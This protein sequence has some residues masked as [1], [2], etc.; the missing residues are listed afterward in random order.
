MLK[1]FSE[2]AI[3]YV[4]KLEEILRN[5]YIPETWSYVLRDA[6]L[7]GILSVLCL[8]SF[9]VARALIKYFFKKIIFRTKSK[10]DDRLLSRRFFNR[11]AYVIPA[12]LIVKLLPHAIPYYPGWVAFLL[13]LTYIYVVLILLLAL[14]ALLDSFSDIYATWEVAKYKPIKGYIQLVKIIL[15]CIAAIFIIAIMLNESPLYL[16]T[17]LGAI[18]AVL[19]IIFKDAL[20][21]LVAGI[22]L[23][24][25]DMARPGDWISM[26]KYNADGHVI[27]ISLTTVKVR[28]FDMTMV[29]IP[30]YLMISDSF[31]NWR[32]MY[33]AEGR[34]IKRALNI[35]MNSVDF[36]SE[37][38]L[39][40][41]K[42][43]SLVKDYIERKQNEIDL[44]NQSLAQD[45]NVP[46]NGRKQTNLGIFRA[47][48]EAYLRSLKD[49]NSQTTLMVRQL[50]STDKGIPLELYAFS[51]HKDW[52]PYENV[53]SDIFD[54]LIAS[55]PH[56]GLKLYQSPTGADAR[57]LISHTLG[58][59]E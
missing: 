43:F 53:Q 16:L 2:T 11:M 25:N 44:Y 4:D 47:Y 42:A 13:S 24:A 19:L 39:N 50:P 17:G 10:F 46:V 21:G 9:F 29:Y 14:F 38:M 5:S 58:A 23:S 15:S 28:N 22:Q 32:G 18:S 56:F 37:E 1:S 20:L 26:P 8:L 36:C 6:I 55:L 7:L 45:T 33:E 54:H 51:T 52:I 12:I 48:V 35:D 30:A 59:E 41:L 40:N 34:R 49:I 3:S 27:E 57:A 31:I